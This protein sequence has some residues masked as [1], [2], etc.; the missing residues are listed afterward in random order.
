MGQLPDQLTCEPAHKLCDASHDLLFR[1]CL[2]I[3]RLM[4]SNPTAQYVAIPDISNQNE[5]TLLRKIRMFY[6][7]NITAINVCDRVLLFVWREVKK[8]LS[9]GLSTV[10]QL[11]FFIQDFCKYGFWSTRESC[12]KIIILL[13]NNITIY[14]CLSAAFYIKHT[15]THC[16]KLSPHLPR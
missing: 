16:Q 13:Y 6:S 9:V 8:D 15:F 10:K 3:F 14:L 12:A 4:T 5:N 11:S 2:H 1:Q 7:R